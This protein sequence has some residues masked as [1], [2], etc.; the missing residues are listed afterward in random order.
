MA[1][2][3]LRVGVT[4]DSSIMVIVLRCVAASCGSCGK[5]YD[6]S[7]PQDV[8]CVYFGHSLQI[9]LLKS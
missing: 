3:S 9:I 8:D 1:R 4:T 6:S 5:P 2:S 7:A